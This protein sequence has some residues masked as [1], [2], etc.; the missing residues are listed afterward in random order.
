M[1]RL[2]GIEKR[3][4]KFQ[5]VYPLDLEVPKGEVFGFLGFDVCRIDMP[6][7]DSVLVLRV[8]DVLPV[9]SPSVIAYPLIG[10]I[11]HRPCTG[12]ILN[13][14]G[15]NVEDSVHRCQKT[16]PVAVRADAGLGPLRIAEQDVTR[17]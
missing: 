15:P 8:E 5:A 16:E 10:V 12:R 11:G 1:I 9:E 7:F 2:K 14:A 17:D 3:Y 13:G 4:G 6:V